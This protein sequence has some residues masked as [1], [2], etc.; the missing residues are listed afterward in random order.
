M[1]I[2]LTTGGGIALLQAAIYLPVYAIF[3]MLGGLL[4]M[5]FFKKKLP[6]AGAA[7]SPTATM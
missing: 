6:P 7:R 3:G 4:G 5:A 2:R 1:I